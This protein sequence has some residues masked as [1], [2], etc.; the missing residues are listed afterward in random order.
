MEIQATTGD[1]AVLC[2]QA[3]CADAADLEEVERRFSRQQE[4]RVS[5]ESSEAELLRTGDGL[6][7]SALASEAASVDSDS[8]VAEL[9]ALE[10]RIEKVLHPRRDELLTEKVE[11][12][13][14]FQAMSGSDDAARLAENSQEL[15]SEIRH[16]A[17]DYVRACL[18]SWVL[19]SEIENFRREHRDPILAR[20]SYYFQKLTCGSFAAVE[21]E[22]DDSDQPVLV[23]SRGTGP[24]VRVEGLSTGT[25]DQL[26]LA[27]KLAALDH[28]LESSEPVPF[29][30]DDI[31][32]QFDDD[33]A[34]ATLDVLAELSNRTQVI[35]FTHH[36]RDADQARELGNQGA[37][38]Y[39]HELA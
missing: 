13:R 31:L 24:K 33:R 27:L 32:I 3:G 34:R 5:I 8:A 28:Y 25:R 21:T 18:A 9:D 37:Q 17:G 30:V 2:Q 23:G 12:E 10:A 14:E 15:L 26:F 39:V 22:F 36:R 20:A 6:D 19:R 16:N 4:L 29:I 35:L 38:T 11:A 1:L 7:M